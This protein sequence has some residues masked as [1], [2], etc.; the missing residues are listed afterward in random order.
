MRKSISCL[1]NIEMRIKGMDTDNKQNINNKQKLDIGNQWNI[2][3]KQNITN[4]LQG[5]SEKANIL[6]DALPYI[7][8]FNQKIVVL[9]YGLAGVLSEQQEKSVMED[10][11]LLK[12]VG[13]KPILVHGTQKGADIFRENKRMANLIEQCKVKAIGICGIDLQTIHMMLDNDYIPVIIPN[14]IDNEQEIINPEKTAMEIAVQIKADKFMFL[15]RQSGVMSDQKTI[16]PLL[17]LDEL[18]IQLAKGVADK[19]MC[20][21]LDKG[22]YAIKNGVNRVHFIDGRVEHGILLELFSIKGIG[23]VLLKDR[24]HLYMHEQ[25]R[26]GII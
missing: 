1:I 5:V 20:R 9:D 24:S 23:T 6:I 21:K 11:A 25:Q 3:N 22:I 19:H 4:K 12:T 15:T 17:T 14:D 10:I 16:F 8:D 7:R 26:M 18:Q 13:M 2:D